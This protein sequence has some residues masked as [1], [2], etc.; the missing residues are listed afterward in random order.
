[1]PEQIAE[2]EPAQMTQM[3]EELVKTPDLEARLDQL[4][5][6]VKER[7][8]KERERARQALE[9]VLPA[10]TIRRALTLFDYL[11]EMR[12][13]EVV[14][15]A[16]EGDKYDLHGIAVVLNY[17]PRNHTRHFEPGMKIRGTDSD[18]FKGDILIKDN[19]INDEG[20]AKKLRRAME[21]DSAVLVDIAGYALHS[22]YTI[23]LAHGHSRVLKDHPVAK[24]SFARMGYYAE[25]GTRHRNI[26]AGTALLDDLVVLTLKSD[27]PQVRII[28]R[29]Q[30]LHSTCEGEASYQKPAPSLY[31]SFQK[32]ATAA[33]AAV[34]S[35]FSGVYREA[36]RAL[37]TL[38]AKLP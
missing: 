32:A 9:A 12:D 37:S 33:A 1:M 2:A 35:A 3:T 27:A 18:I 10:A 23:S 8:D 5:K 34:A 15:A 4:T 25:P 28:Y 21:I 38:A 30:V 36:G 11:A 14:R 31:A 13:A 6:D 20:F 22:G 7:T 17:E 16:L 29:G 26:F 19:H 24:A